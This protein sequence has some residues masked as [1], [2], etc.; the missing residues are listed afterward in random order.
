MRR[1]MDAC[2]LVEIYIRPKQRS[3]R[4]K[5]GSETDFERRARVCVSSLKS[6]TSFVFSKRSRYSSGSNCS[7]DR[8]QRAANDLVRFHENPKR[9][10][11]FVIFPAHCLP[12]PLDTKPSVGTESNPNFDRC[13]SCSDNDMD[14]TKEIDKRSC[15]Q[16]YKFRRRRSKRDREG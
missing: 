3:V 14:E 1:C 8:S 9:P 6:V 2:H 16:E 5:T 4:R 13:K 11:V 10:R 7:P 12:S 15:D